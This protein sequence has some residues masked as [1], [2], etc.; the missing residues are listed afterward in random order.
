MARMFCLPVLG[1]ALLLPSVTR[2][3]EQEASTSMLTTR[4]MALGGSGHGLSSST[5]GIFVNPAAMGQ[6]RSYHVDSSVLYDPSIDRWAFGGAV[7]DTTRSR[8]GAGMAYTFNTIGGGENPHES[9]EFRLSV[10]A[11]LAESI[12]LGVTGRYIDYGG[13]VTANG[14]LG[15]KY[16]GV[17]VDVGLLF[18]PVRMF[19]IGVTGYSL[20]DPDTATSP[21]ALGTGIGFFPIENLAINADAFIDFGTFDTARVRWSGGAELLVQRVPIRIGY[22]YDDTRLRNAVHLVTAGV[23]YIDQRFGVEAAMRQE[24]SGGSQTTLLLNLRYFHTLM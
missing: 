4:T 1:A 22:T 9:H 18:R 7:A 23:G 13:R 20:S 16:E 8:F 10:S 21:L 12:S 3:Q 2:A 15:T 5:S 19:S 17:T 14:R 11:N 24:V 6:T